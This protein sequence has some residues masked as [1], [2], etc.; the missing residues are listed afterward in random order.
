MTYRAQTLKPQEII[1][2]NKRLYWTSILFILGA[3]PGISIYTFCTPLQ[4]TCMSSHKDGKPVP[5]TSSSRNTFF[6]PIYLTQRA[7]LTETSMFSYWPISLLFSTETKVVIFP[8]LFQGLRK[9]FSTS[10]VFSPL[11]LCDIWSRTLRSFKL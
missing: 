3:L 8:S 10:I 2:L 1:I 6:F 5:N 7:S 9:H 11:P 4:N